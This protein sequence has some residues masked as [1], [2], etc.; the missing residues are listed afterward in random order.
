[1]ENEHENVIVTEITPEDLLQLVRTKNRTGLIDV[2]EKVP[3]IDIAEAANDFE[4]SD[5][6]AIFRL[7]KSEYTAD[8]FY[9]IS[10]VEKDL[11]L[12]ECR[13]IG[14]DGICTIASDLAAITVNYVANRMGLV[15]NTDECTFV[16]TNKNAMRKRFRAC[17]DPSPR[18]NP[19]RSADEA[20]ALDPVYPVIVKP[21]DRSGSRGI[22][23]VRGPEGL[24]DAVEEALEVSFD[25]T[26][27]IE[28]FATGQEYSAECISWKGEHRL[29]AITRKYT[30]GDPN[31]IET[32][33]IEPSDLSKEMQK[34]VEGIVSHALTSLGIEYGA[35]HSEFKIDSEGNCRIIEI[36][37][38]MGG[39]FIGS[40]LVYQSTGIDFLKAVIDVAMGN[41]PDVV[42]TKDAAAAVRFI[43]TQ[44]DADVLDML[45]GR[46]PE[47]LLEESQHPITS[48][49][50]TDSSTRFGYWIMVS[51]EASDLIPY[52]PED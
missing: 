45:K 10:I 36:G 18:S 40:T 8:F 27:L 38:R 32:A 26:A 52:L 4:P 24:A 35:S 41:E 25:K 21:V 23:L 39:D 15:G 3:T 11:I 43:F 51:D 17:G 44:A 50:V 6:I 30:T 1:M 12:G 46:S 2:F 49:R 9:P 22:N 16:S 33:H 48:Q 5:L 14:I 31:F 29:L 20:S 34:K 13:R 28:E 7:V 42:R 47:L 19:V 37:G